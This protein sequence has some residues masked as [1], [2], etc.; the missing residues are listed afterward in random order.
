MKTLQKN[1]ARI[2]ELQDEQRSLLQ[3]K[4]EKLLKPKKKKPAVKTRA[5]LPAMK[6]E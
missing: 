6:R 5:D 2:L 3:P 4:I 1:I